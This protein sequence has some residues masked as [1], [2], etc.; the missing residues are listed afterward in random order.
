MADK[1]DVVSLEGRSETNSETNMILVVVDMGEHITN[2]RMNTDMVDN[3]LYLV[4]DIYFSKYTQNT[5]IQCISVA[6]SSRAF[7]TCLSHHSCMRSSPVSS[8]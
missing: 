5:T 6:S 1:L 7:L 3:E 4:H 8:G 2:E